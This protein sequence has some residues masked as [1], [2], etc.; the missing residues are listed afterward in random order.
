MIAPQAFVEEN[1]CLRNGHMKRCHES[2]CLLKVTLD[3][4]TAC[5]WC[6]ISRPTDPMTGEILPC[7]D[8]DP[9]EGS[10]I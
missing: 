4:C 6:I 10:Q 9:G 8:P 3:G 5:K 1:W 7:G 2:S